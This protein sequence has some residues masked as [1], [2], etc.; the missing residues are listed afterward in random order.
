VQRGT[1][2]DV[3]REHILSVL[4]STGG[5]VEGS[6]DVSEGKS[7]PSERADPVEPLDGVVVVDPVACI[8]PRRRTEQSDVLV[9]VEGADCQ[10]GR[11]RQVADLAFHG[12]DRTTSRRVSCKSR[13][14]RIRHD[15]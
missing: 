12:R 14:A 10:A 1:L 3:Q 11:G 8:G 2:D 4:R 7:Q 5:V 15:R 6:P 9:V 13:L